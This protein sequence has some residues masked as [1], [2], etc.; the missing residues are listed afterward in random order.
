[1]KTCIIKF[2][3]PTKA[4]NAHPNN[5]DYVENCDNILTAIEVLRNYYS[6]EDMDLIISIEIK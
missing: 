2:S 6:R 1:M 4:L 5:M 3:G